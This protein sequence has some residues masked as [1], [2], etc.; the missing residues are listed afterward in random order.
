MTDKFT[1]EC[2]PLFLSTALL[3]MMHDSGDYSFVKDKDLVYRACSLAFAK[4]A[5]LS[6][7]DEVIGKTD[8]ELFNKELADKYRADD[9]MVLEGS[10]SVDGVI[11]GIPSEGGRK[12]WVKT[13][14]YSITDAAGN[15]TGMYGI[16]RNVTRTVEL[17]A[18]TK[19]IESQS[20]LKEA[21]NSS[22]IQFFTYFPAEKSI[23]IYALNDH[24]DSMAIQWPDFPGTFIDYVKL[25]DADAESYRNMVKAIDNGDERASCT[26]RMYYKGVYI[27]MRVIMT[28]V[29][30]ENGRTIRALGYSIDVTSQVNAEN[31]LREERLR[32]RSLG[33]DSFEAY[34]C[35]ITQKTNTKALTENELCCQNEIMSCAD[36]IPDESERSRF[37]ELFS[38]DG[39]RKAFEDGHLKSALMYRR[40]VNGLMKWVSTSV[41]ILPDPS[42]GDLQGFIY[43]FD[44]SDKVISEKINEKIIGKNY[45]IVSYYDGQ[46]GT[47][48]IKSSSDEA[49]H[50]VDGLAYD[51]VLETYV[52]K[53]VIPEEKAIV[54]EN[55]DIRRIMALLEEEPLISFYYTVNER[56]KTLPG[57]PLRKKRNDISYLDEDRGIIVFLL[58]DVTEIFEHDREV[59]EQLL[60]ALSAAERANKA[61]TEFLSRISHDIR[62]PISIISSM[63]DFAMS[64]MD[65]REKLTADLEKIRSSNTFLLSLI[66]DVLDISKID[67]GKIELAPEP[68]PYAEYID[69]VRNVLEQMCLSKGL[70][71]SIDR[72][73]RTGVLIAD[74]IRLNQITFNL[75]ANAVKYTPPGGTVSYTSDS[76]DLPGNKIRQVM[77]ISDTGIGMS[78]EFQKKMFEPFSQEFDNPK[79]EKGETGTGLGLSIVKRLGDLMGSKITVESELGKGTTIRCETVFPKYSDEDEY[80]VKPE[81]ADDDMQKAVKLNG[82]ILVAEDNAI[83]VEIVKRILDEFGLESDIAENGKKAADM[84]ACSEE[85]TY[86]AVLMDIQMPLMNGYDATK[87]I[88]KLER[89]DAVRIPVIAMTADAFRDAMER[90]LES[91]MD[92]YL[93]KPIDKKLLYSILSKRIGR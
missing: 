85:G 79:R 20:R 75:L 35:N 88:R 58:T 40:K 92:D 36:D 6:A 26:V 27:W 62:T 83:N 23:E 39:M 2:D 38:L 68:Y 1:T 14:K 81:K 29:E 67:S 49:A 25:S 66:N 34:S 61:K 46:T 9:I 50:A 45:D 63:T 7:E 8:Y 33:E 74:K 89:K 17:E 64:D 30:K 51:E 71:Y 56:H 44:V 41:E 86:S 48:K 80:A 32:L 53:F 54:R 70:N 4:M 78:R 59:R 60:E 16:G 47:L 76:R 24:Y 90:G 12:Q 11:E 72:R 42:T 93:T 55:F 31:R 82:K 37:I 43:S 84:F 69:N 65:D 19:M 10:G 52:N 87:A 57:E 21:I 3:K 77:V 18:E 22:D 91:G 5:G 28:S 15:V 13:W 73:R